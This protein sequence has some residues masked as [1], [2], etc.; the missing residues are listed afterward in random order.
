MLALPEKCE[1]IEPV[2]QAKLCAVF[3]HSQASQ[4]LFCELDACGLLSQM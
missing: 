2:L 1:K 3:L 4:F